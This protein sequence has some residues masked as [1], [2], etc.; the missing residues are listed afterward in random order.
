MSI[1]VLLVHAGAS[2][3]IYG[4]DLANSLIAVEQPLWCRLIASWL[5]DNKYS[6][7]ILDQEAEGIS[8]KEAALRTIKLNPRLVGI[9]VAGHQP[10]ASTQQMYGAR[11]YAQALRDF[12]CRGIV[13][14]LGNHP[15]AL[16]VRT[17][18][19]EPV[20]FVCDGEGPLTIQG[21][22]ERN[23]LEDILGLVWWRNN[24]V[25]Q[26]P[27]AKLLP[28][29]SIHGNVWHLLKMPLYRSHNWQRFTDLSKRQPYASI[30]TSLGCS[31][32]CNFCM[33]N[34][35][36]HTNLYRMRDPKAVVTEMVMLNKE[37]KV[38]TF[39]FTDELFVLNKKH[40]EAVCNGLIDAG[41]GDKISTWCYS[42]TDSFDPGMLSLF[43]K[44][45]FD[46]FAL[47]IES[48]S[49]EVRD[50]SL[51]KLKNNDIVGAVKKIQDAGINVIGNYIFGLPQDNLETMQETLN[52][53][54]ELNTE[55][56]NFYS[57]MAYPGSALY[58]EAISNNW[59]LPQ[60]WQAYSQHNSECRPLD[61]L[62]IDAAEVLRFRDM[63]FTKY[64]TN[65]A[66]LGM[67]DKK[68]GKKALEHI[69][70]MTTFKLK[71]KLLE[72][73]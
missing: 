30:H 20:D 31:Y 15:S 55:F 11:A 10:S 52:L 42:R 7:D 21:L 43:R 38:E 57:C 14:M 62:Y 49:K 28:I 33:I 5:I 72:A 34:V 50:N 1:D 44:A 68:F 40:C 56:A 59:I 25:I 67:V 29:D 8:A 63:A 53:A 45:G 70:G 37:Y 17:L 24:K 60:T 65:P 26:N 48:G 54:M 32:K 64:F 36:Q 22:L 18:E 12:G 19:E 69:K 2:H 4:S 16:P 9:V 51:K 73:V 47:G 27:L 71:R 61:T 35:F 3:G 66:Y 6:V 23:V 41:I 13:L 39:K 46:W 58:E